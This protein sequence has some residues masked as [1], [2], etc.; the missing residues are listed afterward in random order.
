MTDYPIPTLIPPTPIFLQSK[1]GKHVI[2]SAGI[3]AMTKE[4]NKEIY[5]LYAG[6]EQ[7]LRLSFDR[8]KERDEFFDSIKETISEMVFVPGHDDAEVIN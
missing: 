8:V 6:Q 5:L 3:L 2:S 7:M 1:S 4:T